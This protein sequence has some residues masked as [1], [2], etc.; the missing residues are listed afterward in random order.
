MH[1]YPDGAARSGILLTELQSSSI[2]QGHLFSPLPQRPQLMATLDHIN[3]K[4]GKGSLA[5]A[6]L[7]KKHRPWTM[8]QSNKSP[9]YTSQWDDLAVVKIK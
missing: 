1:V 2:Q 4:W 5:S 7:S 3:A 9:R 6:S 8:S